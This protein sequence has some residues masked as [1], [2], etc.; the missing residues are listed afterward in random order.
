M[1]EFLVELAKFLGTD[2]GYQIIGL[3]TIAMIILFGA[4]AAM[5]VAILGDREE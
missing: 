2:L 1:S 3:G 5:L 4:M